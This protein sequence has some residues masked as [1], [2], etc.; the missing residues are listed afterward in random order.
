M[1]TEYSKLAFH[2]DLSATSGQQALNLLGDY[3]RAGPGII[4]WPLRA[5]FP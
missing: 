4:S 5:P 2:S 3:S 1:I